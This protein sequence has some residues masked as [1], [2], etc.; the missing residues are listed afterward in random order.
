MT[1]KQGL[2]MKGEEWTV[3]KTLRWTAAYFQTHGIEQSRTDA[4]VLLAH[5][6]SITRIEI[7]TNHDKPLHAEELKTFK[8]FIQRRITH[9]PV[10]YITGKKEFWSLELTVTPD[11]LVP[12]PETE[13]LVEAVLD[14]MVGREAG[15]NSL[16]MGTGSGAIVCALASER[17]RNRYY[18]VDRSESALLV[19]RR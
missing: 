8:S 1:A 2:S 14:V 18:A 16:D 17:P 7:Y 3:M 10:A 11:V 6:L 12:R 4:E 15:N 9:E 5:A 13:C 19:A